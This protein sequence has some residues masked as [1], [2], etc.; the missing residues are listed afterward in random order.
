MQLN[1]SRLLTFGLDALQDVLPDRLLDVGLGFGRWGILAREVCDSERGRIRSEN[2]RTHIEAV[3]ATPNQVE[4]YHHFFY[5]QIHVIDPV[6]YLETITDQW[7]LIVI[8]QISRDLP[9]IRWRRLMDASLQQAA[10]VL[11]LT[12]ISAEVQADESPSLAASDLLASTSVR[13]VLEMIEGKDYG[14]FLFSGTD[15][16][17]LRTLRRALPVFSR[18]FQDNSWLERESRSGP[19]SSL[20]QT[21]TI[22]RD[23]PALLASLGIR[24]FLDAPCG[25]F[26]WLRH[27]DLGVERYIGVDIVPEMIVRNQ[28]EFASPERRFLTLDVTADPLPRMDLIL[29][30][31]ALVHMSFEDAFRVVANFRRSESIY[32]LATTFPALE[33]N[34][35]AHT[36]SWRPLNLRLQPFL[37]P[38]PI[39]ILNEGCSEA[40]GRYRDKSLGLWRLADLMRDML[41]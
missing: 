30:R 13:H 14:G 17:G 12:P 33:W 36:G 21:A 24:S 38:E 27:V 20:V 6:E 35:P 1:T 29:C 39:A 23:I 16:R 4:E 11:V 18:I 15:P 31:D 28:L 37:F 40:N 19:G 9:A 8:D 7:D 5:D 41:M 26:N 10:Y 2:W 22:R 25:D 3:T 34:Y 32:L